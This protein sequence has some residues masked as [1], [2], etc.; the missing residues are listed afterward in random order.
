MWFRK[1]SQDLQTAKLLLAQ[2][3]EVFWGP[4]VF[5]SQQAAEKSIK[6]FLAA[7]KIR[8]A[9]TH[10]MEILINLVSTADQSLGMEL[11]PAKILTQ[12]AVAYR[13][14]EEK[15]PPELTVSP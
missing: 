7:Q 12:F 10:D 11:E 8:F 5:H 6:G 15:E 1:A 2:N 13:Y 14:P 3:S 4:A 9:K